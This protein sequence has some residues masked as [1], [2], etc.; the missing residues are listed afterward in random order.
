MNHS[1]TIFNSLSRQ[2]E[3]FEPHV[4][5]K[6]GLY[7]CGPTVYSHAHLG[8]ARPAVTFDL[9]YRYLQHLGY[10]V[11]YVRNITDVGHLE[12]EVEETGEDKIAKKARI[13]QLEPME[14]VQKYMNGFHKN[15]EE[16]NTLPPSIEPRASGHIPEQLAMI[17]TI[18]NKGFAYESNGSVY[19]DVEK[20]N[21]KHRYGKLS[22]RKLEDLMANTRHLEGQDQKRNPFDFAL[23]KKANPEHIMRW[24]SKWSEGFPGWHLECSAMSTKYLGEYFDIHGGGMDLRFP[25][26]DCEIAQSTVAFGHENVRYWMHNNM[27]TINGQKMARSLGNFIT[28]NEIF[29][30]NH[31]LLLQ[32]YSPMTVRF[33]ILLAHYRSTL[34]FSNEALQAAGKGLER[35][36]KAGELLEKLKPSS[37]STVDVDLLEKAG[38]EA[39]NDDLNTPV[40]IAHLF[41]FVRMI[42]SLNDGNGSISETDLSKLKRMFRTFVTDIMGLKQETPSS[43]GSDK[44]KEIVNLVLRIRQDAKARKEWDLSD[45]IRGELGKIGITVKDKKDGY[46]WEFK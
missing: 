15:M 33:F 46:E 4:K 44:L 17:E 16:L 24:T 37:V 26:H 7:V 31:P 39:L 41:D 2:K 13:E 20:Y 38:Y 12:D 9:L 40:L 22:G 23:W 32:P 28:L 30:G 8:H 5:G 10:Q 42:N 25:H 35:L 34:D 6:A 29:N 3:V 11:R 21:E 43:E 1:F 45:L 19:F 14:V 36:M 18:L 27:V